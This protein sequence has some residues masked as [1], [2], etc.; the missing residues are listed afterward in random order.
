MIAVVWSIFG[1]FDEVTI[2][3]GQV[4]PNGKLK[5]LQTPE[6][7]I[8]VNIAVEEGDVVEAG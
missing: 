7:G 8:I 4:I 3:R 1:K 5:V 2:G 6:S